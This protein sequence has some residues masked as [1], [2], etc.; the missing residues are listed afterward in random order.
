MSRSDL[1]ALQ[2]VSTIVFACQ[3]P[4]RAV[5]FLALLAINGP[6]VGVQEVRHDPST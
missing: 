6:A 2:S 3:S 1:G 4:S 5:A